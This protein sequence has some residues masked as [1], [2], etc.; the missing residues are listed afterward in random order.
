M[1]IRNLMTVFAPAALI[2]AAGCGDAKP[3]EVV[4]QVDR[5]PRVRV[6]SLEQGIVFED[7]ARVQGT[8]RT[9]FSAAV[10]S[11]IAGTIDEIMVDEGD[12]VKADQP[13]FQI[14]KV[15]LENQVRIAEDDRNVAKAALAEAEAAKAEALAAFEKAELDS[16]RMERLYNEKKA[17]TQ[18]AWERATLNLKSSAAVLARAKAGVETAKVKIAQTETAFQIAQKNLADSLGKAPFDGVITQKLKDTG[19]YAASG[20]AV[21]KMDNPSIYEISFSMNADQYGKID[22]EKTLIRLADGRKLKPSYQS[23][24]VNG[25]TRTFELRT[26]V[27]RTPDLAPGMIRS[28]DVVFSSRSGAGVPASAE[29]LRGGEHVVFIVKDG[30]VAQVPVK[31]GLRT[32]GKVEITN[33]EVLQG[34]QIVK[35]GMLLLNPGDQVIPVPEEAAA[36]Q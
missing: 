13:L 1:T 24:T 27:D 34:A 26:V 32:G 7:A 25:T 35:E 11:R 19:D 6:C 20:N 3:D 17:V 16:G 28:A 4:E 22:F 14:D 18:D 15:N 31:V 36:K 21:F 10:A 9:K 23:P 5:R 12:R 33:P 8:V 30:V 29:G 2:L